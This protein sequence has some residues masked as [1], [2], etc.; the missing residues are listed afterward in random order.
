ME[1]HTWLQKRYDRLSCRLPQIRVT[2]LLFQIL[3]RDLALRN[4]LLTGNHIVKIS[5]FGMSR[6]DITNSVY[7]K[8]FS[9]DVPLPIF[10]MAVES[11]ATGHYTKTSDV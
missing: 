3:H 5:D 11:L 2:S 4:L 1:W 10:W 7:H 8:K 6:Q 9:A